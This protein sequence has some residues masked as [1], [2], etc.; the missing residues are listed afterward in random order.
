MGTVIIG[1][2]SFLAL[3]NV[4]NAELGTRLRNH[5]YAVKVFVDPHQID[6]SKAA[7][8]PDIEIYPLLDFRL[9]EYQRLKKWLG[10]MEL[11]RKSFKDPGTFLS[12]LRYRLA[13]RRVMK[14]GVLPQFAIGWGLGALGSYRLCC[15]RALAELRKTPPYAAYLEMLE[16]ENPALVAGFSPEGNREMALLQAAA[17]LGIPTLI[18]I[19][20]RD[21][22]AS[23]IAFLPK[24]DEYLVWSEH[25]KAYFYHLYPELKS[26]PVSVVGSPQFSRHKD[27]AFRLCRNEFF[28]RVKLDPDRPL[29]VFC[30]ENPAVV[31]HQS[32]MAV[33]LAK[34]FEEGRI[35]HEAQLLIR[36]HPR[37]FG[38]DYDPL[39]GERFKDV[40]VYPT[41]TPIPLGKHDSDLVRWILEDEP[42][43]LA[44]MAYQDVN[45]NIM[46]TTIIDSAILDKPV[47]NVAFDI[48]ENVSAS[49]SVKRFFKR[50]DYKLIEKAGATERANSLDELVGLINACLDNPQQKS[51]ERAFLVEQD[52]GFS[53]Q[54]SC[55]EVLNTIL[56]LASE[57]VDE[58]RASPY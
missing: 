11:S 25:Q 13:S 34:A 58:S 35:G 47:I 29:V 12:K 46:S 15:K 40:A 52:I 10:W 21:N 55:N 31:P 44:T 43:H 2:D 8:V 51:K 49:V 41:P 16:Q 1:C 5:G 57:M 24:V 6:G 17:D 36:N 22:L 53:G 48:P 14:Y 33:A 30:L 26:C 37:A 54:Q 4:R 56:N 27:E 32:N 7:N 39:T 18:M 19:R 42:M 9:T 50:S 3:R 23:K 38:S 28:E 20:S 45:V